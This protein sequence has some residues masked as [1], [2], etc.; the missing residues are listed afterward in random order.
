MELN[1]SREYA[2][3][4]LRGVKRGLFTKVPAKKREICNVAGDTLSKSRCTCA[5]LPS[6]P[7]AATLH[8]PPPSAALLPSLATACH[9]SV[10]PTSMSSYGHFQL[11]VAAQLA[12]CRHSLR[13]QE[14]GGRVAVQLAL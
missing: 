6:P 13:E 9:A 5:V 12:R 3:G 10:S 7:S 1:T 8:S 14:E 2:E 11:K 4:D